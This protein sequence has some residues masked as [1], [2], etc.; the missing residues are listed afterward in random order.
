M[1][2]TLLRIASDLHL[3]FFKGNKVGDLARHFLPAHIRDSAAVLVLAGDISSDVPQLSSFLRLIAPRFKAVI[4]VPGNHEY[5]GSDY[6]EWNMLAHEE[7]S[8]IPTLH[9]AVGSLCSTEIDGQH[10]HM[11]TLWG[12]GGDTEDEEVAIASY[13]NDFKVI[14]RNG[15]PF[16]VTKMQDIHDAQRTLLA[17]RLPTA[18]DAIVVTH[19]MPSYALSHPRFGN[20]AT[21]GFAGKCDDMMTG[22]NAPKLWIHGHT[23]YTIDRVIGKTRIVC[24][25]AGYM[26]EWQTNFNRFFAAPL[27]VNP[28]NEHQG[29]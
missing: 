8:D 18:P 7:L 25:P 24:N 29:T 1:A 5:Y 21:G 27:F 10:F 14:R 19:H 23:H 9:A 17:L 6:D 22:P 16:T 11:G 26:P 28:P 2:E 15:H 3:E 4:Y 13:L 12:D 20:V